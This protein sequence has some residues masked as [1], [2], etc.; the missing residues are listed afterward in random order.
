MKFSYNI[1]R[2]R[3][4]FR[5]LNLTIVS[6]FFLAIGSQVLMAQDYEIKHDSTASAVWF[7]G[8]DRANIGPRHI[9]F[10]QGV[11]ID[12]SITIDNFSFFFGQ[13][14][15]Y[16]GN[17]EGFGHE[18]TLA[19]NIRDTLGTVLQTSYTTLADTFS[20]GWATWSDLAFNIDG[21]TTLIFTCYLVGAIDSSQFTSTTVGDQNASYPGGMQYSKNGSS[22]E[23]MDDWTDWNPYDRRDVSFWLQGT[24]HETTA[25]EEAMKVPNQISLAQNYPNPFNPETTIRYSIPNQSHTKLE[26]FNLLGQRITTLVNKTVAEGGHS[27]RWQ[28]KDDAGNVVPSGVYVYKLQNQG[29]IKSKKLILM[30]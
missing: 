16:A 21:N 8:D 15:D 9:G 1:F 28:G 6:C 22:D 12:T 29:Y 24:F 2:A 17:P 5:I 7:G 26:I 10:G 3:N 13:H 19:L 20:Y 4:S 23:D 11:Y 14:F 30:K 25:I 27:I 18:V